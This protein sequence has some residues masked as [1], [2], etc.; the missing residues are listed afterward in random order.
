M[1]A[2]VAP[3]A[4]GGEHVV[5][6]GME[7]EKDP[8]VELHVRVVDA[9]YVPAAQEKDH[10]PL[11]SAEDTTL[12]AVGA[13]HAAHDGPLPLKVLVEAVLEQ[14]TVVDAP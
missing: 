12:V 8:V 1:L 6:V 4:A 14:V 2:A 10:T 13:T 7:P 3:V 9:P 5:H 11:P